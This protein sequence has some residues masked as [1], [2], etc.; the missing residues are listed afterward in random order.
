MIAAVASIELRRTSDWTIRITELSICRLLSYHIFVVWE[1][2][3][4]LV[5]TALV[6]AW[7][8]WCGKT[9][10]VS[11]GTALVRAW[12]SWCGK[13]I[14]VFVGVRWSEFRCWFPE[15]LDCRWHELAYRAHSTFRPV[16]PE[17]SLNNTKCLFLQKS[18]VHQQGII[19]TFARWTW[20]MPIILL[21]IRY[22][23]C[24]CRSPI[25]CCPS[26]TTCILTC[27]L[28]KYHYI[29]HCYC[30]ALG[31]LYHSCVCRGSV[32]IELVSRMN[33]IYKILPT[34]YKSNFIL[35]VLRYRV[36]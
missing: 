10:R 2:I 9:I 33:S 31:I 29:H 20:C 13:T 23:M 4:V 32:I 27:H 30:C 11:V 36:V 1:N 3:R 19:P 35:V 22:N 6:R 21:S 17:Q 15:F 18:R 7:Y 24:A 14:R 5:D 25:H 28:P 16:P 26:G 12:Y 34:R 8:L